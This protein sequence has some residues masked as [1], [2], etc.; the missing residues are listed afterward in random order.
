MNQKFSRK[1]IFHLFFNVSIFHSQSNMRLWGSPYSEAEVLIVCRGRM[2][3]PKIKKSQS[4]Y[5]FFF[6]LEV[7]QFT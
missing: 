4:Y 2:D 7:S 3:L 1:N 5:D 6:N